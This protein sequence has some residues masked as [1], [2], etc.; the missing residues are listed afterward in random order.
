MKLY[1]PLQRDICQILA[2]VPLMIIYQIG[3]DGNRGKF[4]RRV[5]DA[6]DANRKL[7]EVRS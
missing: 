1:P 4:M 2:I 3:H 6:A 5:F 7:G